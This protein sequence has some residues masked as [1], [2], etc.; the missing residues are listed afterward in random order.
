MLNRT[1]FLAFLLLLTLFAN[2]TQGQQPLVPLPGS[3]AENGRIAVSG[4]I[5]NR[6]TATNARGIDFITDGSMEAG[7]EDEPGNNPF[8]QQTSTSYGTVIC[9]VQTCAFGGTSN[10][11][12]GPR[13]GTKFAWFGG[14]FTPTDTVGNETGTLSQDVT[15]TASG[16]VKLEFY[17]WIG[18]FEQ[19]GDDTLT[20][21]L[22][23]TQLISIGEDNPTYHNG[24]ALVSLDISSFAD[25]Q[26]RNLK[27]TG[28]DLKATNTNFS[29][30]D[31][32]I[33]INGVTA[34]PTEGGVEP[35]DE[36]PQPTETD[37]P[38]DGVNI[39]DNGGFEDSLTAWQ[40]KN[41]TKDKVKCNKPGKDFARN[42]QCAFMFKG[43]PGEKAKLRQTVDLTTL[44]TAAG[45]ELLVVVWMK[46]SS[47]PNVKAKLVVNYSD[48]TPKVKVKFG[49]AETDG[50]DRFTGQHN[51]VTGAASSA[52]LS[53]DNKNTFGKFFVDDLRLFYTAETA[54]TET[55]NVVPTDT[56]QAATSTIEPTE[57]PEF[58]KT[59]DDATPTITTEPSTSTPS[60]TPTIT[61]EPP[62]NTPSSTP[63]NTVES[64]TDTPTATPTDSL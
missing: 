57:T 24:Y 63:T 4:D 33:L 30:D 15:I 41:P 27:F 29:V 36:G 7:P 50:Y 23:N 3:S 34:T 18:E 28:T 40:I 38:V 2:L 11:T 35:T 32:A 48:N 17:L 55:P 51:F 45:E 42:G 54:A 22:G 25:G 6:N 52:R 14:A 37:T 9:T 10:T 21:A 26:E 53:I 31:I 20:V 61:T 12:V 16:T 8:W 56:P 13:T 39:L 60:N 19:G 58:T 46:A 62:T 5:A 43:F 1:R 44:G 64:P 49:F 59:P 47:T